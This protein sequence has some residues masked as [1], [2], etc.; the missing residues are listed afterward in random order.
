MSVIYI[1]EFENFF[2]KM[3]FVAAYEKNVRF[4]NAESKISSF[5]A[6]LKSR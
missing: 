3:K 5:Y 1:C 2:K 4:L 6:L